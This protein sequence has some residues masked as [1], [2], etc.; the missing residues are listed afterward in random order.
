VKQSLRLA[1]CIALALLASEVA[2]FVFSDGTIAE[3]TARGRAV[4]EIDGP[5]GSKV[6]LLGR[7]GITEPVGSGYV[8][9]WNTAKL[10]QLPPAIHDLIFFHECAHAQIPTTDELSANCAGL[11]AMRTAGRAGFAVESKLAVFYGP[12]N[13]YWAGTLKCA[14]AASEPAP[15]TSR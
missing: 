15:K 7:T 8:I 9:Q 3:C 14:D 12:G 1:A 5:P 11:K 6:V 4:I 2:A 13:P 10:E